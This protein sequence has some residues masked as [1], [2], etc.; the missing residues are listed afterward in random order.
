MCHC[1]S[2]TSTCTETKTRVVM[3]QA[4]RKATPEEPPRPHSTSSSSAL[5]AWHRPGDRQWRDRSICGLRHVSKQYPTASDARLPNA[6]GAPQL[7][8]P[9]RPSPSLVSWKSHGRAQ[10]VGDRLAAER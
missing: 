3:L 5:Y 9:C 10:V 1:A 7:S 8:L 4:N 2:T 6:P